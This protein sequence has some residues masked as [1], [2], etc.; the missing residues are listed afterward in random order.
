[1]NKVVEKNFIAKKRPFNMAK[2]N[3]KVK[4]KLPLDKINPGDIYV[5]VQ[6]NGT[7]IIIKR[8]EEMMVPK[9]YVDL[10]KEAGYLD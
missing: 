2:M 5:P 1:M 9:C 3:E 6:I 4:I 7:K 10:L 8:G